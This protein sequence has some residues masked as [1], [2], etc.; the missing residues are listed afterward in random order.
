MTVGVKKKF[1]LLPQSFGYAEIQLP[2]GGS[3]SD[4]QR[5]PLQ[6]SFPLFVGTGVLDDPRSLPLELRPSLREVDVRSTDK[7]ASLPEG[8]GIG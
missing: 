7:V 6:C 1:S 3:L 2:L 8:G 5:S 4:D